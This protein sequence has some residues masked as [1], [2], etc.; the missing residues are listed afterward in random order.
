MNYISKGK[1]I[2]HG[3]EVYVAEI[4]GATF[5]LRTALSVRQNNEK[6][7]VFLDN[8]TAV[9]ALQTGESSSSIRLTKIF[10]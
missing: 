4:F 8:K 10:S 1:G 3:G 5:A 6:I 7:F 9:M 2:L